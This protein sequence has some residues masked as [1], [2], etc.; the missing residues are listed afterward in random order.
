LCMIFGSLATKPPGK[1]TIEK[2]FAQPE[3]AFKPAT[4]AA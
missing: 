3:Q 4:V 1:E 2:Y